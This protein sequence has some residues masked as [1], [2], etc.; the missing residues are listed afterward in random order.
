MVDELLE[1]IRKHF[2]TVDRD[3]IVGTLKGIDML[4]AMVISAAGAYDVAGLCAADGATSL[5]AW[6]QD[7][8]GR[9]PR[10]AAGMVRTAGRLRHLPVAGLA[11]DRHPH[12]HGRMES[13]GRSR[14]RPA[15]R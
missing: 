4:T 15:R 3:S 11:C 12:D 2:V 13:P 8:G 5:T 1:A 6:L 10:T 14:R 9:E 7:P